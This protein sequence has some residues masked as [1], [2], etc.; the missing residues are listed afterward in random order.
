MAFNFAGYQ[1][2]I[3]KTD[4]EHI[5]DGKP[6]RYSP[7]EL[8]Q[9]RN[10]VKVRAKV[11][12]ERE[13]RGLVNLAFLMGE[14]DVLYKNGQLQRQAIETVLHYS[15]TGAQEGGTLDR[16]EAMGEINR[17]FENLLIQPVLK[18]AIKSSQTDFKFI[19]QPVSA[20]EGDRIKARAAEKF[21]KVISRP[22]NV[23]FGRSRMRSTLNSMIDGNYFIWPVYDASAGVRRAVFKTTQTETL[24]PLVDEEGRQITDGETKLYAATDRKGAHPLEV[25]YVRE[26]E[27]ALRHIPLRDMLVPGGY[28]YLDDCPDCIVRMPIRVEDLK[29]FEGTSL[30]PI[31]KVMDGV[32]GFVPNRYSYREK[33]LNQLQNA[34]SLAVADVGAGDEDNTGDGKFVILYH[35]LQKPTADYPEGRWL[36]F[37]IGG[38]QSDTSGEIYL[39]QE[40]PLPDE[41]L[42]GIPI[43]EHSGPKIDGRFQGVTL[44]EFAIPAQVRH[45]KL[46]TQR[47][48]K[49]ARAGEADLLWDTRFAPKLDRIPGHV[50]LY[51][52]DSLAK[53]NPPQYLR[54]PDIPAELFKEDISPQIYIEKLFGLYDPKYP[55]RSDRTATEVAIL[56]Q[57]SAQWVR[58]F[59][60]LSQARAYG[61]V[62]FWMVWLFKEYATYGKYGQ[63]LNEFNQWE[64]ELF[65][66][67]QIDC[68][69]IV[70]DEKSLIAQDRLLLQHKLQLAVQINPEYFK[71]PEGKKIFQRILDLEEVLEGGEKSAERSNA[72]AEN[73]E[74]YRKLKLRQPLVLSKRPVPDE[75]DITHLAEHLGT[76]SKPIIHDLPQ[77]L[78]DRYI[79][80]I[81]RHCMTVH[82]PRLKLR[83]AKIKTMGGQP[84]P[85]YL[86][87]IMRVELA[88]AEMGVKIEKE[89]ASGEPA[90]VSSELESRLGLPSDRRVVIRTPDLLE[91]EQA[92]KGGEVKRIPAQMLLAKTLGEPAQSAP[93]K[94]GAESPEE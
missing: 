5:P 80:A 10:K 90:G 37:V 68:T 43:I 62:A 3:K 61:R 22:G 13:A 73:G 72:V 82:L 25:S 6:K 57:E 11:A 60:I 42:N 8:E 46:L 23:D 71:T 31:K 32:E 55:Q 59:G 29:A 77:A 34:T 74:F 15:T 67:S 39:L 7:E 24:F 54:P 48:G 63:I 35:Y 92:A 86:E 93:R 79:E 14:Q 58:D 36:S 17:E 9:L 51:K 18:M 83:D 27:L 21:I 94:P 52:Y 49:Y 85:V 69:D 65:L 2:S 20:S 30:T 56:A 16:I 47:M 81:I 45:N 91:M 4:K 26:G 41:G 53:G 75:D 89:S 88:A 78:R 66:Q 64:R 33:V 28:T 70:V 1:I 12:K 87:Y 50:S 44:L 19:A 40:F 38:K 76:I 84:N